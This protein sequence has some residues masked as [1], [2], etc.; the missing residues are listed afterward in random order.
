MVSTPRETVRE[1]YQELEEIAEVKH[2]DADQ[3]VENAD[4]FR[5]FFD[6][7]YHVLPDEYSSGATTE[8]DESA[9]STI[10]G[11]LSGVHEKVDNVFDGV[12]NTAK[13]ADPRQAALWGIGV[14]LAFSGTGIPAAAT[15]ST[16]YLIS[17]SVLGGAAVGLYSSA[18]EDTIFD[19]IDPMALAESAFHGA[20]RG[21]AVKGQAGQQIGAVLGMSSYMAETLSPEEYRHWIEEAEPDRIIEGAVLGARTAGPDDSNT[22]RALA[23]GGLGLLYGYLDTDDQQSF[24]ELVDEDLYAEYVERL[25]N[26]ATDDEDDED[27]A[28]LLDADLYQE[29]KEK[30]NSS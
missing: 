2:I 14:G 16:T 8:D 24:K 25:E 5:E 7:F 9:L 30:T 23:G 11:G 26:K 4:S 27:L 3:L 6:T 19:D 13:N 17:G 22:Q 21:K 15:Y 29:F 12:R 10:T 1:A 18:N 20:Q 28:Q